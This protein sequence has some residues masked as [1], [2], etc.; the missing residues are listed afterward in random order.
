MPTGT[1]VNIVG[2][3]SITS[4]QIV[5]ASFTVFISIG[6]RTPVFAASGLVS[7]GAAATA[8]LNGAKPGS[9]VFAIGIGGGVTTPYTF[10]GATQ[11]NQYQSKPKITGVASATASGAGSA[12]VTYDTGGASSR[13]DILLFAEAA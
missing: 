1:T 5:G 13:L 8:T 6:A 10:T 2:T 3:T 4:T 11:L 7:S 9:P 12:T